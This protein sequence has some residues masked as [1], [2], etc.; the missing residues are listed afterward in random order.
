MQVFD[1]DFPSLLQ[2]PGPK[3]PTASHPLFQSQP[4]QGACDVI[5]FHPRHDLTL[6][7]LSEEDIR[8]IIKEWKRVYLARGTQ[9]GVKYI[10]IFEVSLI[11]TLC[12][13]SYSNGTDRIKDQ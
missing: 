7:L 5:V 1:N 12:R 13:D 3:Q 9:L 8:S 11:S 6:A 10:Q 4:V 2:P